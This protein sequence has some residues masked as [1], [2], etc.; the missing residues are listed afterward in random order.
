MKK[1]S[2][3]RPIMIVAIMMLI[4][5]GIA[6]GVVK[7]AKAKLIVALVI[8]ALFIIFAILRLALKIKIF[9][10]FAAVALFVSLPFFN[11]YF[12]NLKSED[13]QS[14]NN[15]EISINGKI[16]ETRLYSENSFYVVLDNVTAFGEAETKKLNGKITFYVSAKNLDLSEFKIGSVIEAKGKFKFYSISS[17]DGGESARY[18][19]KNIVASGYVNFYDINFTGTFN[20]SLRDIIREAVHNKLNTFGGRFS[21][22]GYGMLFGD[23]YEVESEILGTFRTTGIAHILA[24]S[25]LHISVIVLV[26]NFILNKLKAPKLLQII[27]LSVLLGF[28]CYVCDFSISVLRASLLAVFLLSVRMLGRCYDRLTALSFIALLILIFNPLQLFSISFV[29]SFSAVLSIILISVPLLRFFN[30]FLNKKLASTLAIITS[31]QI[32]V[33]VSTIF[34]FGRFSV[35]SLLTNFVS[36]PIASIAFVYLIFATLFSF[37][38]PFIAP[39]LELFSIIISVVVKFNFWIAGL[40]LVIDFAQLKWIA[41]VTAIAVM[42]IFSDYV[43]IKKEKK[44]IICAIMILTCSFCSVM[45]LI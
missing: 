27:L 15:T 26:I 33:L 7:S 4:A 17:S 37:V 41:I 43:F 39:A 45:F 44:A 10:L 12:R 31:V 19:S 20:P 2:N 25:G 9:A 18:L 24:V 13:F 29:L 22:I 3:T 16:F 36:I 38:M 40:G 6:I 5:C 30:K 28:Y 1:I 34:Y 23:S 14:F 32:G 8:F 35:L 11:L 21:D 42:Y